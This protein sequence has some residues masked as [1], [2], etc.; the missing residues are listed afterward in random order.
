MKNF[1][2]LMVLSSSLNAMAFTSTTFDF[3]NVSSHT[4][5]SPTASTLR[6]KEAAQV[7][8]DVQEFMATGTL[9]IELEKK[10]NDQLS[11]NESLSEEE[12]L[13]LLLSE[14]EMILSQV[15]K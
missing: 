6:H 9:S 2:A 14:A 5:F 11:L 13:E 8:M 4:T 3:I 1:L 10:I 15:S 12:A 7:V